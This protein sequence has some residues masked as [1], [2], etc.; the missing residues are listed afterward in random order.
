MK[1]GNLSEQQRK[2]LL[3]LLVLGMYSDGKLGSTEDAL[4]RSILDAFQFGSDYARNQYLDA[5]IARVR[6][7]ALTKDS[8]RAYAMSLA[9]SFASEEEKRAVY[10]I[11][12]RVLSSDNEVSAKESA[13]LSVVR[14]VL[15]MEGK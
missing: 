1:I 10:D 5:S 7:K 6:G 3:D 15:K 4:V 12:G 11:L 2:A 8:A 14:E 13:L 9:Q